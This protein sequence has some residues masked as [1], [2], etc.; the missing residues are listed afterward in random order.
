M[1]TVLP[2]NLDTAGITLGSLGIL[3]SVNRLIRLFINTPIGSL[4]DRTPRRRLFLPALFIGVLSTF[5]YALTSGFWPLFV[6]R[7]LWGIAW[8]GIWVGGNTIILDLA[9]TEDR[10]RWIGIYQGA[11]FFGAASGAILG[12]VLTDA[13]GYYRAMGAIGVI[14]LIGSILVTI[15]LPETFQFTNKQ[16]H[17]IDLNSNGT[18]LTANPSRRIERYSAFALLGVNRLVVA[19]VISST[20]ALFIEE[21]LGQQIFVQGYRIGVATLAGSSLGLS[22]LVSMASVPIISRSSDHAYTRWWTVAGGLASGVIGYLMLSTRTLPAISMGIV[23]I[24][25]MSGSNTALATILTGDLS[26]PASRSRQLGV[27]FTIG[28]LGSTIGPLVTFAIYPEVSLP[29]IY[30]GIAIIIGLMLAI[31]LVWVRR[32]SLKN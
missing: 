20:L 7:V 17:S 8:T 6:G 12:G 19:G 28:D 18:E 3:L 22:T 2:I 27:L 1:Y 13:V 11:F 9:K 23:L 16:T 15:L 24:A 32:S 14:G 25:L 29:T 21:S 26:L 31:S 10:G 4:Y 5:I 30:I